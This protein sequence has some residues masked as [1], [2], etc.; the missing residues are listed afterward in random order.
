MLLLSFD[1]FKLFCPVLVLFLFKLIKKTNCPFQA[2]W[3]WRWEMWKQNGSNYFPVYS[4]WPVYLKFMMQNI[5]NCFL[6]GL[7]WRTWSHNLKQN[8]NYLKYTTSCE[9]ALSSAFKYFF[10]LLFIN[11]DLWTFSSY[12]DKVDHLVKPLIL[13]YIFLHVIFHI[14]YI[15]Y[16]E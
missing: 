9:I 13:N 10:Y 5:A 7:S 15:S 11:W 6:L 14:S 2:H 3:G 12:S 4:T 8:C 16:M 1:T